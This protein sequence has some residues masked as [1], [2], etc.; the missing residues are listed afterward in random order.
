MDS[1]CF[2]YFV[3][4]NYSQPNIMAGMHA[5]WTIKKNSDVGPCKLKR[6]NISIVYHVLAENSLE[7]QKRI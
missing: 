2:I 4:L 7:A 5:C 3:P 1:F 6:Y